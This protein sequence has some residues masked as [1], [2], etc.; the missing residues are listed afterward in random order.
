MHPRGVCRRVLKL[1]GAWEGPLGE[2]CCCQPDS[3]NPTVRDERGACGNVSYGGTR[4]P[5]HNRKGACRKLS[6]YGCARRISTRRENVVF[7]SRRDGVDN[8]YRKAVDGTGVVERLSESANRHYR[9]TF[10]PDGSRLVLLELSAKPRS[11]DLAVLT[12]DGEPAVEPLLDTDFV[13]DNAHLSPDGRWLAHESNASGSYEIYVRPFPN[14][15]SGRWQISTDGGRYS[16]WGPDGHELF[17][18]I[19][20]GDLWRVEIGTESELRAG[21]P[22]SLIEGGS[23]YVGRPDRSFE[24]RFEG[25]S[26]EAYRVAVL[27]SIRCRIEHTR[28]AKP[29]LFRRSSHG[30]SHVSDELRNSIEYVLI[31]LTCLRGHP[32]T[33]QGFGDGV[34]FQE[35]STK[36]NTLNLCPA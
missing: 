4:I 19:P 11:L 31:T 7:S 13:L 6:T 34:F 26:V 25:R 35:I 12:L 33:T 1:R 16:L 3:G 5:P 14:V 32:N 2:S 15:D 29:E 28:S 17:F 23:Y 27:E 8:L 18:K 10:T 22:E 21:N 24:I 20:G 36:D 30:V 9:L